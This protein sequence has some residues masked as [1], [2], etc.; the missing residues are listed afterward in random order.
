MAMV[1]RNHV[2]AV[3]PVPTAHMYVLWGAE[4]RELPAS[5]TDD[6]F[7]GRA[8][9]VLSMH[10]GLN[11]GGKF[12]LNTQWQITG[13]GCRQECPGNKTKHVMIDVVEARNKQREAKTGWHSL[14]NSLGKW[15]FSIQDWTQ[16]EQRMLW[17]KGRLNG[18]H[19]KAD[20]FAILLLSWK[21]G[22]FSPF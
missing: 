9:P 21:F 11:D 1:Q 10:V 20:F 17:N 19:G 2:A 8:G 4:A 13:K 22:F 15:I 6:T 18:I 5:P 14:W 16:A 7:P 3:S 12:S